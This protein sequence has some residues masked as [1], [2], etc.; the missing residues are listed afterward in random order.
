M[1]CSALRICDVK[2]TVLLLVCVVSLAINLAVAATLGR[3]MWASRSEV[4]L[5][6]KDLEQI[7]FDIEKNSNQ[8]QSIKNEL[9][10]KRTH[11]LDMITQ[12]P[13][14][15]IPEQE[16]GEVIAL[17]AQMERLAME[18]LR[19]VADKLSPDDRRNFIQAI[20]TRCCGRGMGM[21]C[22]TQGCPLR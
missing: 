19:S 17:Q 7:K 3:H 5:P 16:I 8:L 21:G 10:A 11:V 4:K 15:P 14:A 6:A 22:G 18:R 2:K 12:N 1:R 9:I 13:G 20:K